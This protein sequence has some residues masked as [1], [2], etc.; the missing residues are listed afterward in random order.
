MMSL[1]VNS[2]DVS[3][4]SWDL[5]ILDVVLILLYCFLGYK[6]ALFSIHLDISNSIAALELKFK[7]TLLAMLCLVNSIVVHFLHFT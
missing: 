4:S 3:V 1:G 6:C 5:L 2:H 7:L